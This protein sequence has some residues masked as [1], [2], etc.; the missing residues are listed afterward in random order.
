L[1]TPFSD[2]FE[3]DS[4]HRLETVLAVA[5]HLGV[6]IPL[7]EIQSLLP[8]ARTSTDEDVVRGLGP[9]VSVVDGI[10]YPAGVR[11]LEGPP[12]TAV[13]TAKYLR[14]AEE[15]LTN[16]L[17]P[18]AALVRCSGVT[19]STAYGSVTEDDDL[20]LFVVTVPGAV[21][22]VLATA[23]L[24]LRRR[25]S[26]PQSAGEPTWC[27]NFVVDESAALSEYRQPQGLH[28]ARE[29]LTVKVVQG[30]DAYRTML[31]EAEW[32]GHEAPRLYAR[33]RGQ[34]WPAPAASTPARPWVRV[35][36]WV[37]YLLVAPYQQA[38][39]LV[40]NAR[41]RRQGRG[42]E[43]FRVVTLPS[44][45]AVRSER[46]RRLSTIYAQESFQ[47][48]GSGSTETI[49]LANVVHPPEPG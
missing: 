24:R 41:L 29:A 13:L 6:G 45:F 23:F 39:A 30:Q 5:K 26:S 44:R 25:R 49:P 7:S 43:C 37:A 28:F 40:R 1:L 17:D 31:G 12:H 14:L 38:S 8:T 2:A 36:N 9:S 18:V 15:F 46:Y 48:R 35:C 33:W 22:I 4:L 10:V 21:W 32:M 20:D 3:D 16:E 34:G 19:G 47:R 27:L 11:R 42:A